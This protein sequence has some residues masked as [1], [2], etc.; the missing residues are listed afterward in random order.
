M[1]VI[2]YI[3]FNIN[4]VKQRSD[5]VQERDDFVHKKRIKKLFD[6]ITNLDS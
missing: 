6:F 3:H 2:L 4:F 1:V 5:D